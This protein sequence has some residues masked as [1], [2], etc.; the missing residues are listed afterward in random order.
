MMERRSQKMLILVLALLLAAP[1]LALVRSGGAQAQAAGD[2]WATGAPMTTARF[3]LGLAAASNGKLYAVGGS[4]GGFGLSTVEEYDPASNTW[5]TRA[6][7]PTGRS[8][9]G[10]AAASNGKLYAVGGT[11]GNSTLNTVE[12]YDPASD[13]WATRANMPTPRYGLS[14]YPKSGTRSAKAPRREEERD[15]ESL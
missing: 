2:T 11:G 14:A 1:P 9:L 13:T 10:L 4:S 8:Y 15:D 6:S 3:G 12:E 5:A 7:M